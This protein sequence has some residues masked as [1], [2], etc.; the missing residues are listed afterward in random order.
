MPLLPHAVRCPL[1]LFL[2]GSVLFG[3]LPFVTNS[4]AAPKAQLA[5]SPDNPF[6][7]PA[8]AAPKCRIDELVFASLARQGLRPAR[9]CSDS[10]FVRRVYLDVVGR[11]PQP[12]EV[13][14]FVQSKAPDKRARLIE[15]LLASEDYADYWMMK[16]CDLLRVKSEFPVNLWPN[17]VQAYERWL[18]EALRENMSFDRFA[19]ELLVSNGSNFRSG[20]VNFYRAMQGGDPQTIAKTV[21]LTFLGTRIER[22]TPESRNG[23]AAFFCELSYKGTAEWKEQ[24]VYFDPAKASELGK[25]GLPPVPVF[26]DGTPANLAPGQDP[27]E[28]FAGWLLKPGNPWFAKAIVNRAWSWFL[29]HGLI[30]E[31]DDIR[32]DNPASNPE[33]LAYLEQEFVA[34][35]YD[36]KKLYG[37]ILRSQVYQQSPIASCEVRASES[38]FGCYPVRRLEA[39]VLID[40][41]NQIT[42]T[43]EKYSSAIPEPFTFVPSDKRAVSLGDGSITSSFLELYGRSSRD[44]GLESERNNRPTA[45]QALHLLNSSHIQK[46]IEQSALL[47]N[48]AQARGKP[49]QAINDL[50]LAILSRPPTNDERQQVEAYA[51]NGTAKGREVMADLVWALINSSEFSYRH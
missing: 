4:F 45:T 9:L 15:G 46:K 30:N 50:Y 13:R 33:L 44:T 8:I 23:L 27:R 3:C 43:S 10:V 17:A 16:W 38:S 35:E 31:P 24:I 47:R 34:G 41:L 51:K 32:P 39:E 25:N 20:P 6:D 40:A 37:L 1:K 48:A 18:H 5:S 11:L 29:G 21:A 19:R 2:L 7:G 22:W 28:V 49:G 26:P 14:E 42:G 36:L 12:G